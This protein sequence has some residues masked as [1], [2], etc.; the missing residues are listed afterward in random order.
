MTVLTPA[1]ASALLASL[2][3]P[4][5]CEGCE[6]TFSE[7]VARNRVPYGPFEAH[8]CDGC[9]ERFEMRRGILQARRNAKQEAAT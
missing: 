5:T 7:A 9:R 3:E 2:P 8:L 1:Q 6:A 4:G